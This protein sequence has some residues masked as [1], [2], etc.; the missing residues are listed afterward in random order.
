M[1]KKY[2]FIIFAC[3]VASNVYAY[4]PNEMP[5]T[6]CPIYDKTAQTIATD[7]AVRAND[8]SL[9][10]ASSCPS[11]CERRRRHCGGKQ[12][13]WDEYYNCMDEC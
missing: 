13:C 9:I 8:A 3:I 5:R 7:Q 1:I 6:G 2:L 12:E 4:G 11:R 10:L